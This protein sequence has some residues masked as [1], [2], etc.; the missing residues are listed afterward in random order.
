MLFADDVISLEVLRMLY[1]SLVHS[2][3]TYGLLFGV[4][5]PIVR[6]YSRF[7]KE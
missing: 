6:S 4:I 5:Q 7:K 2:I 3:T 1:F